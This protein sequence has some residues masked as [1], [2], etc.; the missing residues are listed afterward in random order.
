MFIAACLKQSPLLSFFSAGFLCFAAVHPRIYRVQG[1][2]F[3]TTA[4]P[5]EVIVGVQQGQARIEACS[6]SQ[7]Q[8]PTT[9]NPDSR[10]QIAETSHYP[11]PSRQQQQRAAGSRQPAT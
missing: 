5:T 9:H 1:Q 6:S 2:I 8:Q 4:A 7:Q 11:Q 10:Q 3:A